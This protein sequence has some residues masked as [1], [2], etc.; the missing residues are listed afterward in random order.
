MNIVKDEPERLIVQ[1]NMCKKE[2]A[3]DKAAC[4]KTSEGYELEEPIKCSYCGSRDRYITDYNKML[5]RY[6][7]FEKDKNIEKFEAEKRERLNELNNPTKPINQF[8]LRCPKCG[9]N[10]LQ[11]MGNDRKSFSVGKAIG[12]TLIA[13]GIGALA[14]FAGAKGKYDMLCNN[15]GHR[16]KTK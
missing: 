6:N 9:G 3:I 16:W 15:C 8:G 10:N 12:G 4:K 14:G 2:M 7:R 5:K 11:V 13:G 1:C